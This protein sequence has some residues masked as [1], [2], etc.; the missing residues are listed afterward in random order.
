M[1]QKTAKQLR[2]IARERSVGTPL[3][4]YTMN[5]RGSIEVH[6]QSTRGKYHE[7]K[8]AFEQLEEFRRS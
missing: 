7:L 4:S 5:S 8:E 6:P 2:K 3:V 1:N